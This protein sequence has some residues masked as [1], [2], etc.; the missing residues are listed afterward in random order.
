MKGAPPDGRR[1]AGHPA[2]GG[3][4]AQR[5][6]DSQVTVPVAQLVG[7]LQA[8]RAVPCPQHVSNPSASLSGEEGLEVSPLG[9]TATTAS[10]ATSPGL[11]PAAVPGSKVAVP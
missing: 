9:F 2:A 7:A 5:R 6:P 1:D 8:T 4:E 11:E 10:E 3:P